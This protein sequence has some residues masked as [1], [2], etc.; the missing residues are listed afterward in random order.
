M[1]HAY[2]GFYAAGKIIP[3]DTKLFGL[4][5]AAIYYL[6]LQISTQKAWNIEIVRDALLCFIKFYLALLSFL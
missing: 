4:F 2:K 3:N 5:Y 6:A 1:K